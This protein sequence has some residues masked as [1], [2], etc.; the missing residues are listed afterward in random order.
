MVLRGDSFYF[1]STSS[2]RSHLFLR[3]HAARWNPNGNSCCERWWVILTGYISFALSYSRTV[4]RARLCVIS[5]VM[6]LPSR[7]RLGWR[8]INIH[9]GRTHMWFQRPSL[10]YKRG[11]RADIIK[12]RWSIRGDFSKGEGKTRTCSAFADVH[13]IKAILGYDARHVR[14][15]GH[16]VFRQKKKG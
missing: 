6:H 10:Q 11:K 13:I 8:H 7:R 1:F 15:W 5:S 9:R 16:M 14:K 4:R 2:P 3:F 12:N